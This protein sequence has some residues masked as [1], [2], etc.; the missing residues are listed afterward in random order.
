MVLTVFHLKNLFNKIECSLS[1]KFQF[2]DFSNFLEN[3]LVPKETTEKNIQ[4]DNSETV[5]KHEKIF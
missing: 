1:R 2:I 3:H 5:I 4:R